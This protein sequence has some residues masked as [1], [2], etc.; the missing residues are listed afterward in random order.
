MRIRYFLFAH[1]IV[2]YKLPLKVISGHYCLQRSLYTPISEALVCNSLNIQHHCDPSLTQNCTTWTKIRVEYSSPRIAVRNANCCRLF[3]RRSLPLELCCLENWLRFGFTVEN[4]FLLLENLVERSCSLHCAFVFCGSVYGRM[5]RRDLCWLV[6]L[7][8][9]RRR[10]PLLSSICEA[11][12][13]L[14]ESLLCCTR[15]AT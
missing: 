2:F 6:F 15:V 14:I 8:S 5:H 3:R 7:K 4:S 12:F 1:S 10:Y 11:A 9:K 13:I